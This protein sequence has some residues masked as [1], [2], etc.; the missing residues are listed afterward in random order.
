[1][2]NLSLGIIKG[3]EEN[4]RD[5]PG[6]FQSRVAASAFAVRVNIID[7]SSTSIRRIRD[8]IL[9]NHSSL[10][11]MGT[12][13]HKQAMYKFLKSASLFSWF[14]TKWY[15]C[16]LSTYAELKTTQESNKK[17]CLLYHICN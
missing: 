14:T 1:M 15:T 2:I 4:K 12:C 6:I 13:I 7:D 5:W 3:D 9:K 11:I 10:N 17:L 16:N 8:L